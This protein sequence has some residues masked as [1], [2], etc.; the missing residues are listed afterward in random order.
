M[1]AKT[2]EVEPFSVI[3]SKPFDKVVEALKAA[4]GRPDMLQFAKATREARTFT[5]QQREIQKGLGRTG[6]M[7]FMEQA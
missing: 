3:S 4:V 7:T 2:I 5:E 1:P 6:L